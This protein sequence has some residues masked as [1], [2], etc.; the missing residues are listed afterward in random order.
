MES[1]YRIS[2]DGQKGIKIDNDDQKYRTRV[3]LLARMNLATHS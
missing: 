1:V 2:V 3:C